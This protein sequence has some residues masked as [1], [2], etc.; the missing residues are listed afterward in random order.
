MTPL[1][2]SILSP[3]GSHDWWRGNRKFYVALTRKRV[4]N[5]PPR[6]PVGTRWT[7]NAYQQGLVA[8]VRWFGFHP[9]CP[10][11]WDAVGVCGAWLGVTTRRRRHRRH[12]L[13]GLLLASPAHFALPRGVSLPTPLAV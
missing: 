8:D 3:G 11:K 7:N 4:F 5:T 9:H 10:C 1:R 13:Q 12:R 2:A 6:R